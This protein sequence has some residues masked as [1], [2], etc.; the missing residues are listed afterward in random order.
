MKKLIVSLVA[1]ALVLTIT[2]GCN[3]NA[4]KDNKAPAADAAKKD[5]PKDEVKKD[6]AP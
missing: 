6:K 5:A 2:V 4:K 3:N 1:L